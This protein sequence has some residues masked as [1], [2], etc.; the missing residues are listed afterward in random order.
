MKTKRYYLAPLLAV[1]LLQAGV[2]AALGAV[3]FQCPGFDP[4]ADSDTNGDGMLRATDDEIS[5]PLTPSQVCMHLTGGD[6][7]VTMA[8]GKETY[9]FG[10]ANVT[11]L[12]DNQVLETGIFAANFPA[13]S[14]IL[15]E[16]DNFY[17]SLTN[18]GMMLRPD[19]FDAHSVHFHGF[20]NAAPVF[21]GLPDSA[22]A[23]VMGST[24]TYY[25][26]LAEPGTHMYHCHVEA[27]EHM[28][29]GMLGNLY[30]QPAQNRLP[31]NTDLNGFIHHTG[32]KYALNDGDGS[33]YVD[34]EYPIQI[35]SFDPA[36]HDASESVQPLPFAAMKDKYAMLNG[37]GYPDTV[38]PDPLPAPVKNN[39]KVSQPV[40]TLIEAVAGEKVLLRI[41]NLNVTRFYTMASPSIPMQVV[42]KDARLLRGADPDGNGPLLGQNLYYKTSS[43]TLGGGES[44]DVILDT[45]G[46]EPGTYFFYT[47]NLNYLTNNTEDFGG[48][49]TEIL[50]TN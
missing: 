35:G 22:V 16:G 3:S 43:V 45:A 44:V 29:M 18:V 38:N 34:K 15:R 30:V 21:D 41:S 5:N 50:I 24:L 13:P 10:F 48:M 46:I 27:A 47:T 36:F 12:P 31:D 32:Y 23:I 37:R 1:F 19:L 17:L 42:G 25:Y 8:D 9:I 26:Q 11:G 6:G 2:T 33:T 20:P 39:G 40:S 28:Q 7:F 14:I 4:A 49:M